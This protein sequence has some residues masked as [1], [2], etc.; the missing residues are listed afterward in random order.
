MHSDVAEEVAFAGEFFIRRRRGKR[1]MKFSDSDDQ[2]GV[3][4]KKQQNEEQEKEKKK[5]GEEEEGPNKDE[6]TNNAKKINENVAK[7]EEKEENQ[8]VHSQDSFE[9]PGFGGS[10][11]E[12][13]TIDTGSEDKQSP[14]QKDDKDLHISKKPAHN[15]DSS[16]SRD[17]KNFVLIIDNDSGTYRPNSK[18]LPLLQ[19]YLER[20]LPGLKIKAMACDDERLK[21][22]KEEQKPAK[23][24]AKARRIIQSSS[25]SESSS[26]EDEV[27]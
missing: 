8:E 3:K 5:D 21:K 26:D 20:N 17:S 2:A 25:S 14:S 19:E 9:A 4:D 23:E 13:I 12:N 18:Y 15:V 10:E 6:G 24:V 11:D 16:R 27:P 7:E 1:G 22:W